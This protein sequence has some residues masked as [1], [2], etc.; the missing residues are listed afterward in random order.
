MRVSDYKSR[1]WERGQG[2]NKFRNF[3]YIFIVFIVIRLNKIMKMSVNRKKNRRGSR[4][5]F[6][7][8]PILRVREKGNKED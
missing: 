3:K 5:E 8:T 6:S 4:N 1:V 2:W 7:A